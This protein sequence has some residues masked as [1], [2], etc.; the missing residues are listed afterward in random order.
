MLSVTSLCIIFS[1]W[2]WCN[3]KTLYAWRLL[4]VNEVIII[5]QTNGNVRFNSGRWRG[6]IRNTYVFQ[7]LNSIDWIS[8]ANCV[9]EPVEVK[10]PYPWIN[11]PVEFTLGNRAAFVTKSHAISNGFPFIFQS[12]DYEVCDWSP[13]KA[14]ICLPILS[15]LNILSSVPKVRMNQ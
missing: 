12:S 1:S 2:E 10:L 14:D 5:V 13:K 11:L 6:A 15:V 8:S 9:H 3:V 4:N 7:S